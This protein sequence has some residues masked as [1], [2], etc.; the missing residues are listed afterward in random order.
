MIYLYEN[1][2]LTAVFCNAGFTVTRI[3]WM[4]ECSC[5]GL[6]HAFCSHLCEYSRELFAASNSRSVN[7]AY[8]K[9]LQIR[10]QRELC[11]GAHD[12]PPVSLPLTPT[13]R[14]LFLLGTFAASVIWTTVRAEC[15]HLFTYSC[16]S[17][18]TRW[19]HD[20]R[21]CWCKLS[22]HVDPTQFSAFYYFPDLLPILLG[23]VCR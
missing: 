13:R 11:S 9:M 5:N 23:I 7:A 22:Y 6:R 18:N 1:I 21:N 8:T 2:L 3:A 12:A 20:N 14:L 10:F 16:C 4:I 17:M 19:I 15:D